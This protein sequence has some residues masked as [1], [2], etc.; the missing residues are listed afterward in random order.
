MLELTNAERAKHRVPPVKLGNNPSPQI[1]AEH[2]LENCYISHWDAWGQKPLYRYTLTGGDQYAAENGSGIS[3]CPKASDNL[4]VNWPRSWEDEVRE[5]VSGWMSSPGHRSNLLDPRH[6][7]LHVGI[8]IGKY[9]TNMVQVFSGE[10]ITWTDSPSISNATLTTAGHLRN[11]FWDKNG[12]YVLATIEYHPPTQQL[13]RG[14]LAGTYCLEPDV[15]VGKLLDPLQE[16]WYYSDDE[17]GREFTDYNTYTTENSQCVNPYELPANR[18]SP[19]SWEA[20]NAQYNA[21]VELAYAMP[22]V[23]ITAYEIV[24]E[25]IDLSDD[26]REFSIRANLS[27]ILAHYGPGIYTL[28]IWATTPDGEPNPVA[29]YP[30]WWH[31]EPTP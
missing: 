3:Y 30:I 14:Q 12:D 18:P 9:S 28:T 5:T 15:R 11:A 21:S 8:A 29:E 17:T 7:V 19:A 26:G 6:T 23:K 16:G 24:A 25:R 22:D 31:T 13:T 10:Y 2:S 20:A 27:P 4:E 1:H